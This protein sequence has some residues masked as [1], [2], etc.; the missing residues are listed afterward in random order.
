MMLQVVTTLLTHKKTFLI[1]TSDGN[2]ISG[3]K[4]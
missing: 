2:Q 1:G 3:I 4:E